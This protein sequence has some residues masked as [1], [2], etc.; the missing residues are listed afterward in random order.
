MVALGLTIAALIL[1]YPLSLI[2]EALRD[3]SQALDERSDDPKRS[4]WR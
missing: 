2:A 4:I 3:I 1:C